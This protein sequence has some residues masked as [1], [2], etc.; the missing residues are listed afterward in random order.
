MT[1]SSLYSNVLHSQSIQQLW[2]VG[3]YHHV[4]MGVQG[5]EEICRWGGESYIQYN[6]INHSLNQNSHAE[7]CVWK[8]KDQL[9]FFIGLC[10]S[11]CSKVFLVRRHSARPSAHT[12]ESLV[13]LLSVVIAEVAAGVE[14]DPKC[15]CYNYQRQQ[16]RKLLGPN[17]TS[18]ANMQWKHSPSKQRPSLV[19]QPWQSQQAIPGDFYW[20]CSADFCLERTVAQ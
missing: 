4:F 11:S 7:Y 14:R 2:D 10:D 13:S 5:Y 16:Q 20:T 6:G 3:D 12:D 19:H 15:G 9:L 17:R 8:L 18:A 1:A